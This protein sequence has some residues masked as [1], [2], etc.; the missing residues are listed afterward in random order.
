MHARAT[1]SR[2]S[3]TRCILK[4]GTQFPIEVLYSAPL[5]EFSAADLAFEILDRNG[6]QR[7]FKAGFDTAQQESPM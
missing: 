4:C 1:S 2:G 3:V 6:V 7:D 5:R